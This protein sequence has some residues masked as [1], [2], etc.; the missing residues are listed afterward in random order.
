MIWVGRIPRGVHVELK[1][2]KLDF[3]VDATYTTFKLESLRLG[4]LKVKPSLR[5][6]S[7]KVVN[8][9]WSFPI[10]LAWLCLVWSSFV[11]SPLV[12]QWRGWVKEPSE[13]ERS[14]HGEAWLWEGGETWAWEGGEGVTKT[15]EGEWQRMEKRGV[16]GR[17]RDREWRGMC[18]SERC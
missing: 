11:W 14:E 12:W 18:E 3:H 9:A 15:W 7:L 5:Y 10:S 17:V 1:S 4:L 2:L 8:L 6:S 13:W 16:R